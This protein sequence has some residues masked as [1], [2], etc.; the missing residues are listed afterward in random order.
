VL[1]AQ[2][3]HYLTEK[4][5]FVLGVQGIYAQRHF[6]DFFNTSVDGD[7]SRN[8]IYRGINPKAGLIYELN[9]KTRF[10]PI[11]AAACSRPHLTIW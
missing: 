11:S 5:S 4:F 10:S 3:Q 6:S 7:V 9:D 2:L 8:L 1:Y